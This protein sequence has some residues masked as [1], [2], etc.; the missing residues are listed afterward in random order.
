MKGL[1]TPDTA[2]RRSREHGVDEW[3][4]IIWPEVAKQPQ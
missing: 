4:S 1:A 3:I 2:G